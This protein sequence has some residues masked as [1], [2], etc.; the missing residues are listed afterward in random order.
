M[1]IYKNAIASI[2]I[3]VEDYLSPDDR[4]KLSAVRNI[5]AGLLLLYKEKLCDLSPGYDKE[6]FVKIDIRPH[7]DEK[8]EITYLAAGKSKKTVN[9]QQIKDRFSTLNVKVD[10]EVFD[11]INRVRNDVEHYYTVAP[12]PVIKEILAKS[13]ILI[14]DFIYHQFQEEPVDVLGEDCWRELLQIADVYESEKKASVD[15][16]AKIDWKYGTLERAV[17]FVRCPACSSDLIKTDDTVLYSNAVNF[18]CSSCGNP[19]SFTEVVSS[20]VAE[21][22]YGES[23]IAMTDG[24]DEPYGTCP[25][26]GE[27]TYVFEE[28]CCLSCEY[29]MQYGECVRCGAGLSL[30]DQINE[31]LC[32]YCQHLYDKMIDE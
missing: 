1:S 3:G 20:C 8:G 7:R 30:G 10:W 2:Q 24:G 29:E 9:V 32:G 27:E 5:F 22:M 14:K 31:G 26:C 21:A 18:T 13:F 17:E 25:E 11:Q 16:L 4:R 28:G 23:Y 19:F 6:L 15:S 12:E